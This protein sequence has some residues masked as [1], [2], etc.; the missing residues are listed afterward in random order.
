M[1]RTL[2]VRGMLAGLVAGLFVFALARWIGEPQVDRAIAFETAMD[3][4]KGEPPEPEIVSRKVQSSLG[5]LTATVVD[6][7]A[8]GGIFSLV[9]AFALGRIPVASPRTLSALLAGLAFVSLAVVPAL[10][11]PANPPSVGKPETIGMRTAAFFLLIAFSALAMVLAVRVERWLHERLGGWN[12]SAVAGVIFVVVISL[13]SRLL[14]NI[15]EVPADFPVT[16]MWKF[17]V[18]A[19]E[20]QVLLWS[21]LGLFFGWL[22]EK[23]LRAKRLHS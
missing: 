12:A 7:T 1:T 21:V 10:K 22:A 3:Q 2:L 15:N 9:F 17:R 23:G 11:Y 6:G 20:M 13:A 4:A 14:P 19:M 5:L 16:L 8:L 18:A